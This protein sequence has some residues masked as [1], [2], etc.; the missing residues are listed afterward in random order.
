MT[1]PSSVSVFVSAFLLGAGT[2]LLERYIRS[3]KKAT[4]AAIVGSN[5]EE[6]M[7]APRRFGAAIQLKRGMYDRYRELHDAIWPD[8]LERI[9]QSNIRNFVIYYHEETN[10]LYQS[11]EWIGHWKAGS[12]SS[13]DMTEEEEQA[14]LDRDMRAIGDDPITRKWWSECEP[15]Q[16]PF[17]QWKAAAVPGQLL[18]S[19]GGKGDWWAAMECMCTAGHWPTSYSRQTCDPDFVKLTD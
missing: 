6:R 15:C 2:V 18:P 3:K 10:T 12:G 17:S 19:Q 4:A 14:L 7:P 13:A 9:Y 16:Q 5:V 11:F 1:K 8:V